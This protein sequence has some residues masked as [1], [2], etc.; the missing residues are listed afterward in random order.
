MRA[1]FKRELHAYFSSALG[2]VFLAVFLFFAG[3]YFCGS[4]V[5]MDSTDISPVFESMFMILMLLV[6]ILTMRLFSE[7]F[8]AK[9]DQLLLTSPVGLNSMVYGKF[10]AA[11]VVFCCGAVVT[12]IFALIMM[13][14]APIDISVVVGNLV[15]LLLLG[16][17]LISIGLFV[18]TLTQSQVIAAVGA[19]GIILVF[20]YMDSLSSLVPFEWIQTLMTQI[21]FMGRYRNFTSGLL[22]ISD[23]IYFLSFIGVFNFLS[24][25]VLEKKRWS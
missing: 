21:S 1:I 4:V 5:W 13:L 18:S 12:V 22:N 25:R 2:F 23:I 11:F 10:F 14:S 9:T 7:D 17:T 16:A 8:K 6:P 24:T 15:G 19:F 20:M 3:F